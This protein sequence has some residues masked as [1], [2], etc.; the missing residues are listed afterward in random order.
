MEIQWNE[1]TIDY[2]KNRN[3]PGCEGQYIR[4]I[5]DFVKSDVTFYEI[6][7]TYEMLVNDLITKTK[8]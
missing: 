2:F 7:E 1:D 4:E 6:G 3:K 8:R 5:Y